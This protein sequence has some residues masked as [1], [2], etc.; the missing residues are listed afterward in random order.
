MEGFHV[1]LYNQ[2]PAVL[3]GVVVAELDH[4]LEF[5][6]GIDVHQRERNF[7]GRK[8]FLGQTHHYRRVLTYGI[9]HHRIFKLGG[10]LTDDVDGLGLELLQMT[11]TIFCHNQYYLLLFDSKIN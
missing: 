7:S 4:F 6:L 8:G 10:H 9:K 11:Q 5:P 2:V 3:L 1:R